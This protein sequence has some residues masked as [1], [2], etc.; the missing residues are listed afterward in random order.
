MEEDRFMSF[1]ILQ[2][3]VMQVFSFLFVFNF[4]TVAYLSHAKASC[5]FHS[6]EIHKNTIVLRNEKSRQNIDVRSL[7]EQI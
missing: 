4:G 6:V 7:I 1:A 5:S 2:D 3:A